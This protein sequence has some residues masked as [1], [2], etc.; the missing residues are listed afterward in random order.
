MRQSA[1]FAPHIPPRSRSAFGV[2]DEA[3]PQVKP[4]LLLCALTLMIWTYVWRIQDLFP[5]LAALKINLM[6]ATLSIGLF[7]I[8]RHPA[9][10]LGR[11]RT[12]IFLCALALLGLTILAIPLSLWP[13]RSANFLM[14]E[15][16]PNLALLALLAASVRGLR[17]LEWIVLVNV[18]G[19]SAFALFVS[20]KLEVGPGGRLSDLI[21]YD[22]NDL[23]LVIVCTIPFAVY[24]IVRGGWLYR[25]IA[26]CSC[27]LFAS[28]LV[29]TGSRG[30]FL[31]FVSVLAYVLL[32]YSALPKRTRILAAVGGFALLS[33]A[34]GDTYWEK[35]RT[36]RNPQ[37]DYNWSGRSTDGRMEVW[38]R[39]L[40]YMVADPVLGVGL[41][42]FAVADGTLSKE[43]K[44]R[45]ERGAGFKWSAAHNSFLEIGVEL[46]MFGLA[47][48]VG[49]LVSAFRALRRIKSARASKDRPAIRHVALASTLSASLVGFIVCGFF[50]SAAYFSYVYMLLGLTVGLIKINRLDSR[51]ATWLA[52]YRRVALRS[53]PLLPRT[54]SY[55][56]HRSPRHLRYKLEHPSFQNPSEQG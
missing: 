3:D 4:D 7:A 23:A 37:E 48:F 25:L 22:A 13:R 15:F 30:G 39:G 6:A 55:L 41:R 45:A 32:G 11:L 28:T 1:A 40:R 50:L 5:I 8:E 43:S 52:E 16:V 27:M 24:F 19:A 46:G 49:M 35:I 18:L 17:D 31:G 12:P 21:Y 54:G 34:A 36:L 33:L 44:A 26:L 38:R 53:R 56:C 20:L 10:R 14:T 29:K 2:Y 9:R 47:L 42:N 51:P